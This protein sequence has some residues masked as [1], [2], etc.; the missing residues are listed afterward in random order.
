MILKIKN[1]P[2][3]YIVEKCTDTGKIFDKDI[4]KSIEFDNFVWQA[5]QFKGKY[6]ESKKGKE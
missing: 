5:G 3:G 4:A 6:D 2:D 1:I